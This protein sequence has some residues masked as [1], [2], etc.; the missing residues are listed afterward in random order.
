MGFRVEGWSDPIGTW[1]H[2]ASIKVLAG[3]DVELMLAEGVVVLER[4]AGREGLRM[5]LDLDRWTFL[6]VAEPVADV[7]GICAALQLWRHDV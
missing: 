5:P 1:S 6:N 3:V 2:D 7:W 4:A